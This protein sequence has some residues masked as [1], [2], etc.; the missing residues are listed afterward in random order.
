MEALRSGDPRRVGGH[1]LLGRL[2]AGGMGLV[3]LG[4]SP[5][6]MLVAVK[7]VHPHLVE[8]PD[9]RARFRREVGAARA[10][11]GAFT[12]PVVDADPEA[13]LPWLATA[14]LPGVPLDQAVPLPVPAVLALGAGLAE[15]LVSIHRA[16]VVHRDLK[17]SNVIL[18]LDGPRVIDFGIAHAADAAVVT[19][20]GSTVGSP[21]FIAPEQARG[22][23]TGPAADVFSLGAV[24][25]FAATGVG[26]Y[27]Q[28]PPHVLIYRA[29]H[30]RPRLDG[31]TDLALRAVVE[32]C[33]EP[34]PGRRPSPDELLRGLAP[35][36]PP[37]TDL[38]G[39]G[40]LPADLGERI[41]QAGTGIPEPPPTGIETVAAP[42]RRRFLV[43]GGA[44]AAVA[45][46]TGGV[47][48]LVRVLREPAAEPAA[49]PPA[50]SP[51]ASAAPPPM[52]DGKVLWKRPS[53]D[54]YL[55]SSPVVAGG[56][57]FVGSEKGNLLAFDARTGKPRWTY[58]AARRIVTG[59]AAASGLVYALSQDGVLHAVDARTG[60]L[61]WQRTVGNTQADPIVAGGLVYCGGD[62]LNALDAAGGSVRWRGAGAGRTPAAA[63]GAVY[64][65]GEKK[66]VAYDASTGRARWT[67]PSPGGV[68]DAAA[69]NG[70]VCFADFQG[71]KVHAVDA[72]TGKRRWT[73]DI[74]ET[75]TSRP[76][77]TDR[78][79]Y[80]A[81]YGG[82]VSALDP[83][84]GTMR[85]Q[86]QLEG[87]IQDNPVM[88]GGTLYV[89]SGIYSDGGV[90]AVDAA[91]GRKLWRF[92]ADEGV[93]SSPAVAGGIVYTGC[94]DGYLYAL[95]ARGGS[96]TATG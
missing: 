39:V 80:A 23:P 61:K 15:A 94:K 65:P 1:R 49:Q 2:G 32:A 31:V 34:D 70:L 58:R 36:V 54:E 76:V 28:G 47:A 9:F 33:L 8:D 41:A 48:A 10:V 5:G 62:A 77:I 73:F 25:V 19:R 79:V 87:Q 21:G 11:S 27:G 67:Y 71:E 82:K 69:A 46:G 50:T 26:P 96:G 56:Q 12:A 84:T 74:G 86:A 40:W 53:G 57:V 55:V 14:Y 92:Q 30:E 51:A 66:L 90:Y 88:A 16:G 6:G 38:H 7:V 3:Y 17:P 83:A 45:L 44:A 91:T 64:V 20:T 85:W 89:P 35:H 37:S 63:G 24:L 60:R 29:V 52:R 4:R 13:A 78:A 81:D 42:G 68:Q 95:D 43:V 22:A 93:E 18:A 59:P 75:A 72:R